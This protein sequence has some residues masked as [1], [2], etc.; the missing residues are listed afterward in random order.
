MNVVVLSG[1]VGKTPEVRMTPNNTKAVTFSV[2]IDRKDKSG[3]KITDWFNCTSWGKTA[4][5]IESYV[6]SGSAVEVMGSLQTRSWE[7]DKGKHTIFFILVDNVNFQQGNKRND[8]DDDGDMP[9][10][11]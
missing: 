9:F 3:N 2:A 6:K 7:D 4:D 5:F 10:E 1:R 11:T 8:N